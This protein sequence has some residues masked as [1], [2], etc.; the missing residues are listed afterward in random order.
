M[1]L[2]EF[3]GKEGALLAGGQVFLE[4]GGEVG[5]ELS[6]ELGN[7]GEDELDMLRFQVNE[8]ESA[9]LTEDDETLSERHAA[10]AHAEEIVENA[11]AVTE[12]LGGDQSAA[13][14]L[15][16]LHPRFR[17]MAK[18]LRGRRRRKT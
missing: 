8:L 5:L 2:L 4:L 10:A 17:E 18:H 14:I 11:N 7:A 9:E 16:A 12:A 1:G 15:V 3:A 13:E 6:S